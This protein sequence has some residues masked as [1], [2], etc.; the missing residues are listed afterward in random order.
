MN[1]QFD[2]RIFFKW[3]RFNHQLEP[4]M[5]FKFQLFVFGLLVAGETP[6]QNSGFFFTAASSRR[7]ASS[8]VSGIRCWGTSPWPSRSFFSDAKTEDFE[9]KAKSFKLG[10]MFGGI[11]LDAK[12]MVVVS[13]IIYF[14]PYL[15]KW[16]NL[17]YICEMGWNHQPE[18]YG[19]VGGKSEIPL[20]KCIVWV[21][22]TYNDH[23]SKQSLKESGVLFKAPT[24]W[25]KTGISTTTTW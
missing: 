23:C 9:T 21:G 14:H 6:P 12:C 17:T 1:Q 24:L 18:M 7:S 10:P 3:V 5:I 20:Q 15:G 4:V 19:D 25:N 2:L 22:F 11:K 16:A 13:N 8:F